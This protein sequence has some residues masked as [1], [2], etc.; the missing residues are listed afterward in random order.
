MLDK[1]K[2]AFQEFNDSAPR[3]RKLVL[4]P[5]TVALVSAKSGRNLWQVKWEVL[6]EIC[7]FKVDCITVDLICIGFRQKGI[8]TF[9]I[10]DEETPG[11]KELITELS[12]KYGIDES[13]WFENV[14]FPALKENYI[15]LWKS[16]TTT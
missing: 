2:K 11:W 6:E 12:A 7:A 9:L 1:L 16:E 15:V 4:S 13:S 14:A 10:T 3:H 8:E 5:D